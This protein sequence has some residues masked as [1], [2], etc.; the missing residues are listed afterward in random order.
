MGYLG[1]FYLMVLSNYMLKIKLK[2]KKID[3]YGSKNE[4]FSKNG[5]FGTNS[6][7]IR[8]TFWL[9]SIF[10][11]KITPNFFL[12]LI[13]R[14]NLFGPSLSLFLADSTKKLSSIL[15]LIPFG[16]QRTPLV[17][18][19]FDELS[20]SYVRRRWVSSSNRDFAGASGF[21]DKKKCHPLPLPSFF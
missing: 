16:L 21:S 7:L 11:K 10:K 20:G 9:I 19:P 17:F 14:K 13:S 1:R 2:R 5:T 8:I 4:T 15:N 18:K 12:S 6:K 3:R